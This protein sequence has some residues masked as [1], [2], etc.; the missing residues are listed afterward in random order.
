VTHKKSKGRRFARVY[1]EL[2]FLSNEQAYLEMQMKLFR[3]KDVPLQE[4]SFEGQKRAGLKGNPEHFQKGREG[5]HFC[6]TSQANEG[7]KAAHLKHRW[8]EDLIQVCWGK[9]KTGI[10]R[11][12]LRNSLP[13]EV[14]VRR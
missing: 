2:R 6:G 14:V 9:E 12:N 10:K 1:E 3:Q 11:E 4:R 8:E 5:H 7:G 13:G